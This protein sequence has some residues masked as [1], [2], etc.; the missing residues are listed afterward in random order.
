MK[1]DTNSSRSVVRE[2]SSYISRSKET[3]FP[4]EV[5]RKAKHH[6]LDTLAA[7]VSGSKLKPGKLAKSLLI[8]FGTWKK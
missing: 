8:I 2:V 7:I 4:A 5:V 3:E 1:K 6:I